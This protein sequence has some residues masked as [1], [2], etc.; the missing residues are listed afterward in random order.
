LGAE[1]HTIDIVHLSRP[2]EKQHKVVAATEECDKEDDDH[3]SLRLVEEGSR[4]HRVRCVKFPHKECNDE[5]DA[6]NER[7]KVVRAAP[8]VLYLIR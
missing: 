3:G 7:R 5:D 8:G 4:D 6:Q 2:E 1:E